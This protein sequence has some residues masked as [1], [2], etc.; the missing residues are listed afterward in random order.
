MVIA[1]KQKNNKELVISNIKLASLATLAPM[2]G[3][4]DTVYRGLIRLFDKDS[5]MTSEMVSSEALRMNSDK[6]IID[7]NNTEYPLAFQISGHKPELMAEAA[8]T[9]ENISTIIDI[10]M[11]C[12]APK[13][14]SNNDGAKLM[15]DMLLASQI[16]SSVKNAVNIP[17]TVKFRLGWDKN[18]KN[19]IEFAEMA[20]ESGADAICIH[21]RTRSQM[22]SGESDWEAIGKAKES[23]RIPVITNG[24]ITTPEKAKSCLDLTKCDGVAVGRGILADPSLT[25]RINEY[26]KTG[27]IP[28]ELDIKKRLEIMLLHC[29]SEAEY[30]GEIYGVKFFRKFIGWYIKG[31]N[32]AAKHRYNLVRITQLAEMQDYISNIT[33]ATLSDD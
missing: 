5:L 28:P 15:T 10:N 23:V 22:Y 2:A 12:P 21:G 33:L 13:I 9:L 24:D 17:V 14:V 26:L 4:T 29:K 31:I 18:S 16:I 6:T 8:K 30:R 32:D 27:I 20:E 19:C 11:G 1:G 7:H 3:Y 25:Y